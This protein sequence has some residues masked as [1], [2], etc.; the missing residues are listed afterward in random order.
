[1]FFLRPTGR[2]TLVDAQEELATIRTLLC[3]VHD[4]I[5]ASPPRLRSPGEPLVLPGRVYLTDAHFSQPREHSNTEVVDLAVLR[6]ICESGYPHGSR[7]RL[8]SS[9]IDE[10]YVDPGSGIAGYEVDGV[11]MAIKVLR[12]TRYLLVTRVD[13]E[14]ESGVRDRTG[15][16][17]G[18]IEG[19]LWLFRLAGAEPLGGLTFR[20]AAP[21]TAFLYVRRYA[22]DDEILR[23]ARSNAS[24]FYERV[25]VRRLAEDG[26]TL[27]AHDF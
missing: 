27:D 6:E 1:M 21:S 17:P 19:A 8:F 20:L 10:L 4:A 26:V 12:R 3:S 25:I 2:S 22:D 23:A 11:M 18:E 9:V 14:R 13:H 7:T 16:H 24:R 15:L 5:G